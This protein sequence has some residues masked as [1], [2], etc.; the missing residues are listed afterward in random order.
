MDNIF[1]SIPE[2]FDKEIVNVIS[3]HGPLRIERILSKGHTSPAE[4]WY[5][6]SEH[7]WVVVLEGSGTVLFENGSEVTL[8]R[9][10]HLHIPAHARHK[11][12]RTAPDQITVWLA[13][14]YSPF[15]DK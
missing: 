7:E 2:Q 15:A 3:T 8:A 1:S 6:Q 4:G 12:A 5:D 13:I 11:V 10:D 9:G 14:F